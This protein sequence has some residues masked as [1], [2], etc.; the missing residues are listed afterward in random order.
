MSSLWFLVPHLS[1][2]HT[3]DAVDI[4]VGIIE[5]GHRDCV[6]A[7][8]DPVPLGGRV[9][10]EN[11]GPCAEDRLLPGEQNT[12]MFNKTLEKPQVF[13]DCRS[14][15]NITACSQVWL[16]INMCPLALLHLFR[17]PS[18]TP[19]PNLLLLFPHLTGLRLWRMM[20]TETLWTVSQAIRPPPSALLLA[21]LAEKYPRY[22]VNIS[23]QQRAVAVGP[24]WLSHC[25]GLWFSPIYIWMY[26]IRCKN[27][28]NLSRLTIMRGTSFI[29]YNLQICLLLPGERCHS[30]LSNWCCKLVHVLI[31]SRLDYG[32]AVLSRTTQ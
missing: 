2:A 1:P 12:T 21:A 32:D 19:P 13:I 14:I 30:L 25:N 4:P 31:A 28:V 8:W 6:L 11:M 27:T 9:D 17:N 16:W 29:H 7:G 26:S 18:L 22:E 5:E 3:D 15:N 24:L 10:L 23:K 20:L